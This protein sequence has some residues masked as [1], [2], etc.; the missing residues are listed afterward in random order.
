MVAGRSSLVARR[1]GTPLGYRELDV[2]QRSLDALVKI[3]GL[4]AAFPDF[5]KYD[6]SSQLRRAS[7]SI[8]ANIAEGYAKRRSTKEFAAYLTTAMASANEVDVHLE[9][10]LRLQYITGELF[11]DL[12]EEYDHIGRQ[13]RALIRSS[14]SIAPERRATSDER[15]GGT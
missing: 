8:P 9:I 2:Y 1:N 6:L 12:A 15:R 13:L 11:N 4:V 14:H 5:E 7:K 3:H 10:A